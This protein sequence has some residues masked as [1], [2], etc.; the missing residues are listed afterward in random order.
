MKLAIVL[1]AVL[2]IRSKRI[3]FRWE[4]VVKLV[5]VGKLD[6][7]L[8]YVLAVH[9]SAGHWGMVE[10]RSPL[11]FPTVGLLSPVRGFTLCPCLPRQ[12]SMPVMENGILTSPDLALMTLSTWRWRQMWVSPGAGCSES[13]MPRCKWGAATTQVRGQQLGLFNQTNSSSP[14]ICSV[15]IPVPMKGSNYAVRVWKGGE[16]WIL[17]LPWAWKQWNYMANRTWDA[18]MQ[19]PCASCKSWEHYFVIGWNLKYIFGWGPVIFF[20]ANDS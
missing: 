5:C 13:M 19:S 6:A 9:S 16:I 3:N 4:V 12:V 18:L 15:R 2:C 17:P 10:W 7:S 20:S 14:S 11:P 1:G 8:P